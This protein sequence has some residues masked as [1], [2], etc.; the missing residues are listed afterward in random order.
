MST[1]V[2]TVATPLITCRASRCPTQPLGL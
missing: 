1:P 2:H